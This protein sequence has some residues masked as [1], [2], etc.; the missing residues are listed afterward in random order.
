M[1]TI[2]S[3]GSFINTESFLNAMLAL[4]IDSILKQYAQE[5]VNVLAK[6]TPRDSGL[7]ASS[8]GYS[9][10][11]TGDSYSIVWTN[12]DIENGFKVAMMIQY[13]HGTRTGGYVQGIDYINPVMRP[14]FDTIVDKIWK[15]VQAA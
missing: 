6:A 2:E 12:S 7:A 10:K 3:S 4:D 9:I 11:K 14:L 1:I 5:G 15:A 8:W 13:G